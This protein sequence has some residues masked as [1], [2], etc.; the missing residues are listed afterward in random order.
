MK[1]MSVKLGIIVIGLSI[2]GY[3]EAW[4]R[5]WRLFYSN[6]KEIGYYYGGSK[7]SREDLVG[8]PNDLHIRVWVKVEY[9]DKGL[10]EMVQ[11]L[12]KN[13]ENFA[14]TMMEQEL[15]CPYKKWRNLRTDYFSKEGKI[16]NSSSRVGGWKIIGPGSMGEALCKVVYK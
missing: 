4:A 16:I 6:D 10:S 9:T 1:S 13:Y 8:M 11:K 7:R 2:F 3:A 5:E 14:Y 12:G 15:D